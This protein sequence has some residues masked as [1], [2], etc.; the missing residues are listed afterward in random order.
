M[1]IQ[2]KEG[3]GKPLPLTDIQQNNR[4]LRALV[5][6]LAIWTLIVIWVIWKVMAH[7]V[8][9]NIVSRCVC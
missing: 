1:E 2:T 7:D 6:I 3:I 8:L 4:L 5:L 9:N